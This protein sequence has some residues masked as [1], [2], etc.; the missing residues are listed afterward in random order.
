MAGKITVAQLAEQV[1]A[2][3]ES[4]GMIAGAVASGAQSAP[5]SDG[6]AATGDAKP[7]KPTIQSHDPVR[8]AGTDANDNPAGTEGILHA[9]IAGYVTWQPTNRDGVVPMNGNGKPRGAR[10]FP[11]GVVRSLREMDDDTFEQLMAGADEQRAKVYPL[12]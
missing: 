10:R 2:M 8:I 9:D 3:Q 4:I 11:V 5:A 12:A 1:A 7:E 6:D